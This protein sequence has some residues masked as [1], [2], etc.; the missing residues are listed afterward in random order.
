VTVYGSARGVGRPYRGADRRRRTASADVALPRP[1]VLATIAVVC[2]G[3]GTPAFF[4]VHAQGSVTLETSYLALAAS[5]VAVAAGATSLVAWRILGRAFYGWFGVALVV[6]GILHLADGGLASFGFAPAPAVMPLDWLLA[7]GIP[8]Y[9][10]WRAVSDA[11]VNAT[12]AP[13]GSLVS[14]VGG[15][16]L[17]LG[18]LGLVQSAGLVPAWVA[19][20][21]GRQTSGLLA[22]ALWLGVAAVA[23]RGTPGR[24][25]AGRTWAWTVAVLLAASRLVALPAPDASVPQ[26]A[27]S[28]LVLVAASVALGCAIARLQTI[29]GYEDGDRRHLHG[30]LDATR[31]QIAS[32][33]ERLDEWLHDLRNAVAGLR[34]ADAVV[35][36]G[37]DRLLAERAE[38]AAAISAE[39]A[40]LQRLVDPAS[41]L[42]VADVSLEDVVAPVVAAERTLGSRIEFRLQPARVRADH[43]ILARVVQNVLVNARRHA[44]GAA[45]TVSAGARD[46]SVELWVH[47]DGPGIPFHERLAVF[48]RGYRCSSGS[49]E[50]T[51]LGLYVARQLMGAMG[52]GIRVADDGRAGC[53]VVLTLPGADVPMPA[54]RLRAV[55]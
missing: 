13:F 55:S 44:P 17:G 34:A 5:A 37:S 35:R 40:R 8:A 47:D 52:G 6:Y 3:A 33:H 20:T 39:L 22:G 48:Q 36:T 12:F 25:V 38:L 16:V 21:E 28:V 45:I 31:R 14:A 49:Q 27:S 15:G 32:E 23:A 41:S 50:G 4:L 53:S 43:E 30:A 2:L 9:L 10:V 26:L 24:P 54:G 46:G 7:A 42:H 29:L 18:V 1:P 11:E 19:G 51:G